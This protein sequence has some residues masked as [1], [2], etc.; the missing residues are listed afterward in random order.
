MK[1]LALVLATAATLLGTGCG[2]QHSPPPPCN[3]SAVIDWPSFLLANNTTTASCGTAGVTFVDVFANG[4]QVGHFACT[5]PAG[6]VGLAAGSNLVTVEGVDGAGTILYRDQFTVDAATCG[7]QGTFDAQPSEGIVEVSYH[8][9]P[10]DV[11][12]SPG[13]SFVWIRVQD[14]LAGVI[15]ADSASAPETSDT[16]G[17]DFPLRFRLATGSYTLLSTEEVIRGA[18]A[19]SYVAVG[20]NCVPAGFTVGAATT[21]S[22]APVLVDTNAFCP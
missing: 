20:R 6:T 1:P 8:F 11:C 5:G 17:I 12:F 9:S 21:T 18:S 14:D 16:C 13:P 15:A 7:P 10:S 3:P 2:V 4:V 22:V 19:G